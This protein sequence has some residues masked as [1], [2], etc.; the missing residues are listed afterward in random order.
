MNNKGQS[1]ITLIFMYIVFMIGYIM[2]FAGMIAE[3]GQVAVTQNNLTGFEAFFYLNL[4]LFI[5][6]I[7]LIAVV[8]YGYFG[9]GQ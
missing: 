7:S 3:W 4:N 9:G 2:V 1:I 6:V 5:F 8:A